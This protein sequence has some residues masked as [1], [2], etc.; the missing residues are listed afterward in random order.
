VGVAVDRLVHRHVHAAGEVVV[1]VARTLRGDAFEKTLKVAKQER[2]VLVDRQ[3][4]RGVQRLEMQ[5]PHPH[6][7]PAHLFAKAVGDVDEFGG[8]RGV[9]AK[10]LADHHLA[11]KA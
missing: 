9:E 7:G 10:P 4:E 8:P 6:A 11:S 1:L 5:A 2:F 3:A